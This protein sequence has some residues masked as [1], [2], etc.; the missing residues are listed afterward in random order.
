MAEKVDHF[1]DTDRRPTRRYPWDEWTDGGTWKLTRGEDFDAPADQFRNR[2]YAVATRRG[3]K[4]MT[5][6][7]VDEDDREVLLVQF[8]D[9]DVNGFEVDEI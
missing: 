6:K 5:A 2:L 4:V 3:K 1:P 7:R 8:V 9:P